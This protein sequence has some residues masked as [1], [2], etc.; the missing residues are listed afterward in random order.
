VI[1]DMRTNKDSKAAET[2]ESMGPDGR[3]MISV[4]IRDEVKKGMNSGD[5]DRTLQTSYNLSRQV[6]RR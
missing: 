1:N 2:E 4:L 3:K 5:Y 6:Q